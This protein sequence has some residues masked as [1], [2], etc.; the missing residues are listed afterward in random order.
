VFG[1]QRGSETSD[2]A[3]A[4]SSVK[5]GGSAPMTSLCANPSSANAA[6][7]SSISSARSSN[8]S[9]AHAEDALLVGGSVLLGVGLITAFWPSGPEPVGIAAKLTPM[10]GPHVAGLQWSGSF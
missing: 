9:D 8:G 7:C 1:A 10:T 4:T 3:S 2:A 6:S 5:G